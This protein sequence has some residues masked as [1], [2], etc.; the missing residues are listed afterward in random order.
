MMDLRRVRLG[1]EVQGRINWYEGLRINAS[2]TKYA[3]AMQNEC[4]VT[5]DGLSRDVRDYILAETSPYMM[6]RRPQRIILEAG[7]V[8]TGVH[9]LFSGDVI[10]SAISEPPDVRLT[11]T[12]KTGAWAAGRV[13]SDSGPP[14]EQLSSVARRAAELCEVGLSFEA[15]EKNI[16]CFTYSGGAIGMIDALQQ[17]GGVRAFIDDEVLYVTDQDRPVRG[18]HRIL[19]MD[20]GMVGIPKPTLRGVDVK[21]IIDGESSVGGAL[22]IESVMNPSVNG[23]YTIYQLSFEVSSHDDPFFYTAVTAA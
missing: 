5:I 9:R 4:T 15:T 16:A 6:R 13:V 12:A 2:G 1:V 10:S 14:L 17:A 18:R 21:Y 19:T 7:R 23:T 11:L 20:T 22:T 8:S 3:S